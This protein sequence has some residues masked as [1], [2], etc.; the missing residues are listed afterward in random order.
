VSVS[1]FY[2]HLFSTIIYKVKV[3]TR[4]GVGG[5]GCAGSPQGI[6]SR[7][8]SH[9]GC[10]FS[11]LVIGA[12]Q[13]RYPIRL[14]QQREGHKSFWPNPCPGGLHEYL[15]VIAKAATFKKDKLNVLDITTAALWAN[16]QFECL[17]AVCGASRPLDKPPGS[18]AGPAQASDFLAPPVH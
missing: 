9:L 14:L 5:L 15:A 2:I 18:K 16:R 3:S 6:A 1:F 13:R 12:T 8:G 17:L 10:S 4:T 7:N 11:P